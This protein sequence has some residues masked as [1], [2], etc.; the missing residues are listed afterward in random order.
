MSGRAGLIAGA[1]YLWSLPNSALGGVLAVAAMATGGRATLVAGVVEAHG[2][3]LSVVLRRMVPLRGGA[4]AMTLGHVV[5]G[6]DAGCLER[7]RAHE[8]AHVRQYAKWGPLFV[9]VYALASLAVA[10]QG[11]HYYRDNPFE[12]EAVDVALRHPARPRGAC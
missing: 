12:K 7:T 2:G 11:R 3:V 4:S 5:L 1:A 9:P 6:R 8:R 10:L